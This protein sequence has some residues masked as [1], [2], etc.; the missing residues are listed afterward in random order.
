MLE[1]HLYAR[2]RTSAGR[3]GIGDEERDEPG[4]GKSIEPARASHARHLHR[5]VC[6]SRP[7]LTR[8]THAASF[9]F[10]SSTSA[11]SRTADSIF[12]DSEVKP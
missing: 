7:L 12:T 4:H 3:G 1:Q 5:R 10:V 11:A 6:V 8:A 9:A 2:T